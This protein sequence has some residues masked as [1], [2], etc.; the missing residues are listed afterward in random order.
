M[1]THHSPPTVLA[2]Q[3]CFLPSRRLNLQNKLLNLVWCQSLM[4]QHEPCRPFLRYP[5]SVGCEFL[6]VGRVTDQEALLA[7][8]QKV[9]A[10]RVPRLDHLEQ[11]P[12]KALQALP[13]VRLSRGL[14]MSQHPHEHPRFDPQFSGDHHGSVRQCFDIPNQKGQ[15]GMFRVFLQGR[16]SAGER[17]EGRHFS[18]A[19]AL[20]S[21]DVY[22]ANQHPHESF[23]VWHSHIISTGEESEDEESSSVYPS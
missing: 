18:H 11:G 12:A 23:V 4:P 3:R 17:A 5:G 13:D 1:R 6:R 14:Q 21:S 2:R 10:P 15:L 16:P 8:R 22:Q 9:L 19:A 7:K 20:W